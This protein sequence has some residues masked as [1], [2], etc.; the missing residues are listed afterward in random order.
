MAFAAFIGVSILMFCGLSYST[1]QG[2]TLATRVMD[3]QLA[4]FAG[5]FDAAV[6]PAAI[7]ADVQSSLDTAKA[8]P[9]IAHEP[10]VDTL[11]T[12]AALLR[13]GLA[14][15][16]ALPLDERG[17]ASLA[18][19]LETAD[20]YIATAESTVALASKDRSAA[21]A[22]YADLRSQ[23]QALN[24]GFAGLK[25]LVQAI[26]T[27]QL[28]DLTDGDFES[29][30]LAFIAVTGLVLTLGVLIIAHHMARNLTRSL[31]FLGETVEKIGAGDLTGVPKAPGRD[32]LAWLQH[33]LRQMVKTLAHTVIEVNGSADTLASASEEV[34][35]TA[36]SLSQAAGEQAASVE[37]SNAAMEQMAA[38]FQQNAEN[39]RLTDSMAAKASKEAKAGGQAVKDTVA[40]MQEIAVKIAIVDDIAY[41]TNLLALNAAIEAARAGVQG[42][43]FAVVAAEVRKLAERSQLAAQEIGTLTSSSVQMAMRAGMLLETM[44]PD[45]TKTSDLVQEVAA[46]SDEQMAGVGQVSIAMNQINQSTQTNAS[47]SQQLAA[48]AEDMSSRAQQLRELVA[49]FRVG[50]ADAASA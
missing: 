11:N 6:I 43:G 29:T 24:V 41:Q 31:E 33:V 46:A 27:P 9:G 35:A 8:N 20:H 7:D 28:A 37:E 40:A 18:E 30:V 39:A 1:I 45:I 36:Q 48:T 47:A 10:V 15:L 3:K 17:T 23:S 38:S 5:L 49:F 22:R 26:N 12:H 42:K 25:A 14:K 34:N 19:V 21:N 44:V 13:E 2:T 50:T 32:E 4:A 16:N